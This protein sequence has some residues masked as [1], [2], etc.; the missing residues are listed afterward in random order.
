MV[1]S[2]SEKGLFFMAFFYP[3]PMLSADKVQ[4]GKML[5]PF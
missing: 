3:H 5:G 4:L 1:V 2:N